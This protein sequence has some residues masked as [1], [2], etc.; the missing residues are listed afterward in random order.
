MNT[1]EATRSECEQFTGRLRQL[2]D[3]TAELPTARINAYREKWG[4][5]PLTDADRP[6]DVT[7]ETLAVRREV[8]HLNGWGPGSWLVRRYKERGVPTCQACHDLAC[9]M[10]DLGPD[11]CVDQRESLIADILPRAKDWIGENKPWV[12]SL[13]GLGPEVVEDFVLS[14]K[15]GSDIDWAI[16]QARTCPR[17]ASPSKSVKPM[18]TVSTVAVKR[19]PGCCN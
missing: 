5:S 17:E 12:S 6:D 14:R 8:R 4:L 10:D 16:E 2:C 19:K 13:L 18:P 11:G 15:I 3:G 1:N 7:R 9:K